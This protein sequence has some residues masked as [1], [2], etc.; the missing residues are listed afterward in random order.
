MNKDFII[1]NNVL[2]SYIGDNSVSKI[3]IPEGVKEIGENIFNEEL[4]SEEISIVLPKSLKGV[5][6]KKIFN[7][8]AKIVLV[9][10]NKSQ[11][12]KV[13]E[14]VTKET[15]QSQKRVED[16]IDYI[17][18]NK[19]FNNAIV[20]GN[21]SNEFLSIPYGVYSIK[22]PISANIVFIPET[23]NPKYFPKISA[24]F[25]LFECFSLSCDWIPS[26]ALY[27]YEYIKHESVEY[28]NAM[29]E[30]GYNYVKTNKGIIVT[31]FDINIAKFK[32]MP[33]TLEGQKVITLHKVD[34]LNGINGCDRDFTDTNTNLK[35]ALQEL[36]P[37][38]KDKKREIHENLKNKISDD[39]RKLQDQKKAVLEGD[40][41]T[42]K[43]RDKID[44]PYDEE[45]KYDYYTPRASR[46]PISLILA[47]IFAGVAGYFIREPLRV[48][49]TWFLVTGAIFLGLWVFFGIVRFAIFNALNN[50]ER[51]RKLVKGKPVIKYSTRSY[52]HKQMAYVIPE[53]LYLRA[54]R[55]YDNEM[56]KFVTKLQNE[57][58]RANLKSLFDTSDMN[59]GDSYTI[60]DNSGNQI[61]KIDKR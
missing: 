3:V 16:D 51:G 7:T 54:I 59:Y 53:G 31:K 27:V 5:V 46:I 26:S 24:N 39:K 42:K 8:N 38:F 41:I 36:Y 49:V 57:I 47:L 10:G 22:K 55:L 32:T 56:E 58:A 4:L 29:E 48:N 2:K 33:E 14:I 13:K 9:Y 6:D 60:Y 43:K 19:E 61:G 30:K 21:L 15:K 23:V 12:P 40:S 52:Y 20:E 44:D 50:P 18:I 28:V 37:I 25:Y 45:I 34:M 17:K 11:M 1:E 35:E